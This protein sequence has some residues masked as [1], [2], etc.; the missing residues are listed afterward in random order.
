MI[1]GRGLP[2]DYVVP[3]RCSVFDNDNDDREPA[4]HRADYF[5]YAT[6]SDSLLC[7]LP[8]TRP[9]LLSSC[10]PDREPRLLPA[11]NSDS[12]CL[13]SAPCSRSCT[14]I[15]LHL[16]RACSSPINRFG[17]LHDSAAGLVVPFAGPVLSRDAIHVLECLAIDFRA[18]PHRCPIW[19]SMK[20]FCVRIASGVSANGMKCLRARCQATTRYCIPSLFRAGPGWKCKCRGA[21]EVQAGSRDTK[22]TGYWLDTRADRYY[23]FPA[24]S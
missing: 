10:L 7:A 19:K 11:S 16:C 24:S 20:D 13:S 8:N 5:D 2:A 17:A 3:P 14:L 18:Q 1:A 21:V 22:H 4:R 12:S 9:G 15:R 6:L 23:L